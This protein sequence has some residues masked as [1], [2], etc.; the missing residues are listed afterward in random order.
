MLYHVNFTG[1]SVYAPGRH[2]ACY[3]IICAHAFISTFPSY[4]HIIFLQK[5]YNIMFEARFV[6]H[7][8][9]LFLFIQ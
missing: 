8:M 9:G 2:S 7:R 3:F 5:L 4:T 6:Y 1:L